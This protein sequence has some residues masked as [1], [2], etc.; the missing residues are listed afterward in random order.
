MSVIVPTKIKPFLPAIRAILREHPSEAD[1]APK[2][3][4]LASE[5]KLLRREVFMAYRLLVHQK[6][7]K[8]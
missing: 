5:H 2:L 1:A 4:R 7:A 3:R 8:P 6:E